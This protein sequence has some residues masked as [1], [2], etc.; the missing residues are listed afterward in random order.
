MPALAQ[1]HRPPC[2]QLGRGAS[3]GACSTA[4]NGCPRTVARPAMSARR[5][6]SRGAA[7]P[8]RHSHGSA[9]AVRRV[10]MFRN[11]DPL[12]PWGRLYPRGPGEGGGCGCVTTLVSSLASTT[13]SSCTPAC[14]RL[15]GWGRPLPAMS[16]AH[17]PH[18]PPSASAN[19]RSVRARVA[20]ARTATTAAP[21]LP[22]SEPTA[23]SSSSPSSSSFV[24]TQHW[25]PVAALDTLKTDR[26]NPTMLLGE[27]GGY[28]PM[29][30]C[31]MHAPSNP[32]W[33]GNTHG[34]TCAHV[35]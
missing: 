26:P 7:A 24:W 25:W 4:G 27:G 32:P 9:A 19:R 31:S 30:T 8:W 18:A 12:N 23:N 33:M 1:M 28:G 13:H 29:C 20:S 10:T 11:C 6:D 3:A 14:W 34:G 15:N 17:R 5:L 21:P 2:L 22:T 35:E 16:A